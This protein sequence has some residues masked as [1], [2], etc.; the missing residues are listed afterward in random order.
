MM[1]K[2]L[3]LLFVLV[4]GAVALAAPANLALNK[5]YIFNIE[6][7]AG[8]PDNGSKLTDGIYA[9][10]IGYGDPNNLAHLREDFRI[11]VIDLEAVYKIDKVLANFLNQYDVGAYRPEMLGLSVSEDGRRWRVLDY[12]EIYEDEL[13]KEG[14][15]LHQFELD[16]SGTKARY[17]AVKFSTE[18]WVFMDEFEVLGDP[19]SKEESTAKVDIWDIDFEEIEFD[20]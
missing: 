10:V 14:T 9:S 11:V 4:L 15:Y 5:E 7:N 13:P 6:A 2:G 3:L 19:A 12:I 1:K 16:A 17:V 20:F 8:Y 18:I